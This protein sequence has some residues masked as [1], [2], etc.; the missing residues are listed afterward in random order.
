[1]KV[2]IPPP[3]LPLIPPPDDEET[4]RSLPS[5]TEIS[6]SEARQALIKHI[7]NRCCYGKGVAKDMSIIKI[8]HM[9]AFHS[10]SSV[11]TTRKLGINPPA[12]DSH[13][14]IDATNLW[15]IEAKPTANFQNQVSQM[16]VPNTATLRMCHLCGGVGR[17]RCLTCTGNGYES[18]FSCHGDGHKPSFSSGNGERERC[19]KC[20]GSGRLRCW[21]CNGEGRTQCHTCTGTGQLKCFMRLLITWSNHLDDFV[22][23]KASTSVPD[24]QIKSVTGEVVFEEEQHRA[25]TAVP[26]HQIKSVTGEVVFEE[27]QHRRHRVRLIPMASIHY[28]W[29]GAAAQYLVYGHEMRVHAPHYPQ[30]CCCGCLIL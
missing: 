3:P 19:W 29:K 10:L 5:S 11:Y 23:D 18:C 27:E 16:E 7:A 21:K 13:T 6:E 25:S 9:C 1:P 4:T 8:E 26:D 2:D 28:L 12:M 15:Y 20:M 14:S 17:K 22:L 30:T 24:H